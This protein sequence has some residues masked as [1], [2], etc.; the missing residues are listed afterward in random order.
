G[1]NAMIW[2]VVVVP[3]LAPKIIAMAWGRVS[4]RLWAM[5]TTSRLVRLLLWRAVAARQPAAAARHRVPAQRAR[6]A[7]RRGP[8][9]RLRDRRSRNMPPRKRPAPAM[10]P[11]IA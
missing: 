2:T 9:S 6:K 10:Q 3:T 8:A 4:Q 1:L 5:V 7:C 11:V